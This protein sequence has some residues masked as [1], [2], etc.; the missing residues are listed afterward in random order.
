LLSPGLDWTGMRRVAY[1]G[2]C[3]ELTAVPFIMPGLGSA[4]K[5]ISKV[6]L[7]SSHLPALQRAWTEH[8]LGLQACPKCSANGIV[9]P[10]KLHSHRNSPSAKE[11]TLQ[12]QPGGQR[13]A[14]REG[15]L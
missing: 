1:S 13:E 2:P 3:V 12:A 6:H 5:E 4:V 15:G 9:C 10:I 8:A 7:R 11:V 14:A